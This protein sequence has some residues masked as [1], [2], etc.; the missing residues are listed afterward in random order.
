[1][2]YTLLLMRRI[3]LQNNG[4][5]KIYNGR[6]AVSQKKLTTDKA[7]KGRKKIKAI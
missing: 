5:W 1:M 7:G 3:L 2:R 6:Y 4:L